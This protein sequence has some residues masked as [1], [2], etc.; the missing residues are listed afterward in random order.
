MSEGHQIGDRPAAHS[1]I[2]LP[3]RWRILLVIGIACLFASAGGLAYYWF[4]RPTTLTVAVGSQDG[5]A[6]RMMS[7]IAVHLAQVNAPV[8]LSIKETPSALE[9]AAAFSSGAV[10]LAVV[11]GD[12]GD[13][14]S[15][16]AVAII[17]R[18]VVL[19]LAP[20]GSPIDDLDGLKRVT[21]GVIGADINRKIIQ[22]LTQEYGLDRNNVTFKGLALQDARRAIQS[23]EVALL[24]VVAPLTDKYVAVVRG[25][26]T[27]NGKVPILV[28]IETAGAIAERER[29]YESF[30]IPK[31][32]LR[33]SPASPPDDV[34]TLRVPLYLVARKG[35]SDDVIASLTTALTKAHRELVGEWPMLAQFGAP[36]TEA[37]A[38]LPVHPG[39]ATVYNGDQLSFL[40]KW[41]N[42][43][44]L[45]PMTLG[46]LASLAAVARKFLRNDEAVAGGDL[47]NLLY[48]LS[49]RIRMA[50]SAKELEAIDDEIDRLLRSQRTT[51]AADDADA[52]NATSLNVA[53][54]RLETLI[55]ER[56][57]A[58][59]GRSEVR[60]LQSRGA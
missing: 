2:R 5:E 28:P 45:V 22:I 27:Q 23:R 10:D 56:R 31:G 47:L 38:F 18:A 57:A 51:A 13:L 37:G 50:E 29:A 7:A 43:I 46:G 4:S 33:G 9:A 39:A 21:I 48:A 35:L 40:D 44:F 3:R 52:L 59:V 58:L 12:V 30:D 26:F 6:P 16:Q 1:L 55:S 25:L 15:A 20:P 11:R 60:P 8:R 49:A 17:T 32:T 36:D 42:V 54:H 34:S 14:S 19:L 53:A 24:L 41:G